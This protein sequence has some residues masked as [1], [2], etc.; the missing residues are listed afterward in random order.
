MNWSNRSKVLAG[1]CA[2]GGAYGLWRLLSEEVEEDYEEMKKRRNDIEEEEIESEDENVK[3]EERGH[4][5]MKTSGGHGD[6]LRSSSS[7]TPDDVQIDQLL[8]LLRV[9]L[10]QYQFNPKSENNILI[11]IHELILKSR[12]FNNIEE[13]LDSAIVELLS[14]CLETE[15]ERIISSAADLINNL[16]TCN[17]GLSL[18]SSL[19]PIII[20]LLDSHLEKE[21]VHILKSLLITLSNIIC[22]PVYEESNNDF[23]EILFLKITEMYNSEMIKDL[24]DNFIL[25]LAVNLSAQPNANPVLVKSN[26]IFKLES[27]FNSLVQSEYVLRSD[28]ILRSL[29][30]FQNLILFKN[31]KSGNW[32]L[33]GET[34]DR[35][36]QF[37]SSMQLSPA[38][39]ERALSIAKLAQ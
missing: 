3:I 28:F 27:S 20:Q 16:S 31:G 5:D 18:C 30:I 34:F 12:Y 36:N 13:M 2:V 15:N 25:K 23:F 39:V 1:F 7:T 10:P 11:A 33:N 8:H 38:I 14:S 19:V 24:L 6:Q 21:T 32:M 9:S 4:E 22:N 26:F 35:V 29:Y 17:A 37:S